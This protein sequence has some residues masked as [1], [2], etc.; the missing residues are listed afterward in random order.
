MAG[1]VADVRHP[2]WQFR[3]RSVLLL[4]AVFAAALAVVSLKLRQDARFERALQSLNPLGMQHG[5]GSAGLRIECR[6]PR[7][8]LDDV[9]RL[10]VQLEALRQP[11][12]LGFSPGLEIERIDLKRTSISPAALERLRQALPNAKIEH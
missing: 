9:E 4:V 5:V 11:H 8:T 1:N 6:K 2:R 10:L 12:D 3:L 7:F